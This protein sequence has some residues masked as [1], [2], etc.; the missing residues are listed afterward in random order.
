MPLFIEAEPDPTSDLYILKESVIIE[1]IKIN[2]G[3]KW[4]GASI[5]RILWPLI[6]SPFTPK[7]MVPSLVHDFMC[8]SKRGRRDKKTHKLFKKLLIANGVKKSV[9]NTLYIGVRLW[10]LIK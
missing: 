2:K 1:G 5:P 3:E 7:L 8:K 4:N 10:S 6:G 9:A